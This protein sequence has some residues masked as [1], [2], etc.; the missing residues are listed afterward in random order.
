MLADKNSF[1]SDESPL[2]LHFFQEIENLKFISFDI[3]RNYVLNILKSISAQLVCLAV[4]F[5]NKYCVIWPLSQ[6]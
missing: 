4:A 5:V 1:L 3:N 6:S 2:C